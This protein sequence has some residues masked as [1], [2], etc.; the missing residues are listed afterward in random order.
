MVPLILAK[1]VATFVYV[2]FSFRI[3]FRGRASIADAFVLLRIEFRS[4]GR[5]WERGGNDFSFNNDFEK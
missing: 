3:L 5:A 1:A 2:S 4:P